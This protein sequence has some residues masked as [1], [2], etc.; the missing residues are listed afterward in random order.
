MRREGV[1]TGAG[2]DGSA[3]AAGE[4]VAAAEALGAAP[5]PARACRRA[6]GSPDVAQ[7]PP[8][9]STMASAAVAIPTAWS[10]PIGSRRTAAAR[11][12]VETG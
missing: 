11:I 2:P 1:T 7:A 9:I 8:T 12:T 6:A 4:A 5:L 3:E 10:R